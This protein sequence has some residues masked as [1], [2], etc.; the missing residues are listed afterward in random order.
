MWST[1]MIDGSG[2]SADGPIRYGVGRIVE[3]ASTVDVG[4]TARSVALVSEFMHRNASSL[5]LSGTERRSIIE[6][7]KDNG[8]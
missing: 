8:A 5:P 7:A 3:R 6:T 1:R 2:A 4:G